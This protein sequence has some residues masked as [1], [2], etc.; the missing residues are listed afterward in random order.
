MARF[1]NVY[2]DSQSESIAKEFTRQKGNSLRI[3]LVKLLIIFL[4]V[5]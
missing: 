3:T 1:E 4:P 5:R 2:S